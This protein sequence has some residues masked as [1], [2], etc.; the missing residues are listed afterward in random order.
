MT[1]DGERGLE[2]TTGD[3][4]FPFCNG[5]SVLNGEASDDGYYGF[6]FSVHGKILFLRHLLRCIVGCG[7]L[8]E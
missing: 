1:V 4:V 5:K 6:S 7:G 3:E 2:V 8:G